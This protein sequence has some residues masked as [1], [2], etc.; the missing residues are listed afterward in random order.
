[1]KTESFNL[2]KKEFY[3]KRINNNIHIVQIHRITDSSYNTKIYLPHEHLP[4]LI[5]KLQ[6]THIKLTKK[7]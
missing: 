1:M 7:L 6:E 5:K 3:I 4:E 2:G